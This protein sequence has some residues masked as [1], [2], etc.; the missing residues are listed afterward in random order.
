MIFDAQ[1]LL[2]NDQDMTGWDEV[3]ADVST[4]IIDL[5]GAAQDMGPGEVLKLLIQITTTLTGD[6][7]ADGVVATVQ[8]DTVANFASPTS[9]VAATLPATLD[10]GD[11]VHLNLPGS[12][13][14]RYLRIS[15][16]AGDAVTAGKVT[17]GIVAD[18]QRGFGN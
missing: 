15:Y 17:A 13:L 2:S 18:F 11:A 4:N 9:V 3:A 12:G 10:A 6:V 8:T 14:Q 16:Q 1:N 7:T 5:A